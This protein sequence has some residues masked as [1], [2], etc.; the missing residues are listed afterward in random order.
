MLA[1]SGDS[2]DVNP[3]RATVLSKSLIGI[4]RFRVLGR[5]MKQL[6]TTEF[7]VGRSRLFENSAFRV[8]HGVALHRARLGQ[9]PCRPADQRRAFLG[10]VI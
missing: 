5:R 8:A 4:W 1:F 7:V 3:P 9:H 6:L 10:D 2:I